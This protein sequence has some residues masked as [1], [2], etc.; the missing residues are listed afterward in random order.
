MENTENAVSNT[1]KIADYKITMEVK[2]IKGEKDG[3]KYDF[4]AYSGYDNKGKKCKFKFTKACKGQPND[5][6]LFTV[7]VNASDINKDKTT[8]WNEYWIKN[9]V[10]YEV[11][12]GFKQINDEPLPF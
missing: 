4:F 5:E 2:R 1:L 6:G 8:K 7:V 12:D 9:V 11:Y 3:R 10:S